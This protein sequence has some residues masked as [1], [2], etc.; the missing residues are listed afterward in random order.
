MCQ[1]LRYRNNYHTCSELAN[2]EDDV[3][4]NRDHATMPGRSGF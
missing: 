3:L 1:R 4:S 2:V